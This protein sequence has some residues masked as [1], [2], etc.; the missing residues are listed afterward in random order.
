[1]EMVGFVSMESRGGIARTKADGKIS[2]SDPA[3]KK[4]DV[5]GSVGEYVGL[6]LGERK[7]WRCSP[8][9]SGESEADRWLPPDTAVVDVEGATES[10]LARPDGLEANPGCFFRQ[11]STC[12][13]Y[14]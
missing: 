3:S 7:G 10:D 13:L 11:A 14:A 1:M 9:I 6:G 8:M 12:E 5:R 4:A 2:R